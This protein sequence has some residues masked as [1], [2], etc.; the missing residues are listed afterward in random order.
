[1]ERVLLAEGAI[2]VHF[3]LVRGVLLVLHGVVV[4]LLA[5]VASHGHFHAHL[6]APPYYWPLVRLEP[7]KPTA[8]LPS[9]AA[10]V[11]RE[12]ENAHDK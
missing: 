5:L 1:M 9:K 11:P 12:S 10:L 8:S 3:H 4:S 2:L 7:G 6:T